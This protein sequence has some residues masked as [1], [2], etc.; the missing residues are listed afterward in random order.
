MC[1]RD[2]LLAGWGQSI[3]DLLTALVTA[4]VSHACTDTFVWT[5]THDDTWPSRTPLPWPGG[6]TDITRAAEQTMHVLAP[7]L[8]EVA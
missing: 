8:P 6:S 2:R 1:I 5:C 7:W 3:A 4:L